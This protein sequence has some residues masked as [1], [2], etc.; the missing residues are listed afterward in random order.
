MP[1]SA[2]S[3]VSFR[4]TVDLGIPNSA[5]GFDRLRLST[6]LPN[7]SSASTSN[8]RLCSI[9]ASVPD[10]QQPVA[11]QALSRCFCQVLRSAS[12]P[13]GSALVSTEALVTKPTSGHWT[14]AYPELGRGPVS[15]ED[16]VSEEFYDKEREHIFQKTWL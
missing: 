12:R 13:D 15:L 4:L 9:P 3:L 6:T 16:C 2:S 7:S 8:G 1:R 5:A 14:D 10:M 11:V